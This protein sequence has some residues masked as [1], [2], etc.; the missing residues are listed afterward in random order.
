MVAEQSTVT[1]IAAP[2]PSSHSGM[3]AIV[4]PGGVAFRVWAPFAAQVFVGGDF[5][6]WSGDANP[7]ASEGNGYWS[8]DVPGAQNG[9]KYC[10]AIHHPNYPEPLLRTDPYARSVDDDHDKATIL[11]SDY[12]WGDHHFEMPAWNELVIYELHPGS[13]RMATKQE[14]TFP[15]TEYL[16]E[17]GVNAVELLPISGFP[18]DISMGYNTALPFA[19]ESSYAKTATV[20]KDL[21]KTSHAAGIAVILDVVYNHW[22][23]MGLETCLYRFD[24]WYENDGG[25]IYFYN[26]WR[27]HTAFGDRPDFG[28]PEVRQYIRDNALMWLEE[29]QLD[30]LRF[31]STVNIRN[32]HGSEGPYGD[33]PE[34]WSWLQWVNNEIDAHSPWKI[35]IAEDLQNNEWI[36]KDT[37]SGGAGFDAQWGSSFYWPVHEA[38]THPSDQGRDMEKVRDALYGRFCGDAFKRII[39]IENHDEVAECNGKVR[40]PEAIDPGHA[41]SWYAK[42]RSTLG[43]ALL[44]TA[45]GIPMIFQGQ[46]FLSWGTWKDSEPMDWSHL[47][48]FRGIHDLYRDLIHLRR[49]WFDNTRGL[50]GQHINVFHVNNNDKLIA[51]HRWESGGPGDDVI[52]ILNFADRAYDSYAIGFPQE[53]TWWTRFNS[54]WQG[55]DAYFGNFGGYTTTASWGSKDGMPCSGN[56]GIAPY[57]AL[58][59]SQ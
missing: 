28:R 34:G 10:Y 1:S 17:L 36:V 12:D 44:M 35:T 27:R 9:Q 58:I 22:G 48:Q 13:F 3:G 23:P 21:A 47:D 32:A 52:V 41:D 11:A 8:V 42:K 7:L 4:Y 20:L 19:V 40:L 39:Y 37:A 50:R 26:D 51:Y 33:L 30:G 31:D 29:F 43:A 49:N 45:P 54:D 56:V 53:G 15:R 46:E 18:G 57:S 6:N 59:L 2:Q 16:R 55:Y 38:L 5:N 14:G 24:G 25:G